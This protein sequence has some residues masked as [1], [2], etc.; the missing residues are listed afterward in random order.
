MKIKLLT[1]CLLLFTSQVF[2][3]DIMLKCN[4]NVAEGNTIYYLKYSKNILGKISIEHRYDGTWRGF[5]EKKEHTDYDNC[6]K[7]DNKKFS[8]K[9]G[10]CLTNYLSN[11]CKF[12][13]KKISIDF[14]TRE[15]TFSREYGGPR[16]TDITSC[17]RL[18]E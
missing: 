2:A 16:K 15:L 5:C 4:V 14:L 11:T 13:Y 12:S 8:S 9:Y 18:Y 17:S 6:K 1:I 7:K 10:E 3:E